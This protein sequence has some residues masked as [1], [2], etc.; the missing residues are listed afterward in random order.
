MSIGQP[1]YKVV[2]EFEDFELRQYEPYLAAETEVRGE[3]DEVGNVGFRRLADFIGGE[4]E[5]KDEIAMTAPVNQQPAGPGEGEGEEIEMTAPVTQTTAGEDGEGRFTISFIMPSEYTTETLP[6]P[7]NPE[8]EIREVP[9]RLVAA[10]RYS[11]TW[12][13]ERYREHETTLMEAIEAAGY[14]AIGEPVFARYDPPFKPWFMRR[15]EALVEVREVKS[16][17]SGAAE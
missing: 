17:A 9:G 7:T 10:H 3:F 5:P 15:N 11:G 16:A 4:N 1:E 8:I 13:A 2:K 12:S 6:R 14:D